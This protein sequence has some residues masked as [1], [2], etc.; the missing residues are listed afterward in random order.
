MPK[1]TAVTYARVSKKLERKGDPDRGASLERQE[2]SFKDFLA[3]HSLVRKDGWAFAESKSARTAEQR[4]TFQEM[5]AALPRLR[6]DYVVID[7]LDRFTRDLESGYSSLEAIKKLGIQ[8]WE[9]KF[10]E[11]RPF[12]ADDW[13]YIN[14]KFV[15]AKTE[16]ES[17]V[18][19]QIERYKQQRK[20]GFSTSNRAGFGLL[21]W[22]RPVPKPDPNECRRKLIADPDPLK[23][24]ICRQ[25]DEKFLSGWSIR[26]LLAWLKATQPKS[27]AWK[28]CRGLSL[29]LRDEA[30]VVRD[31]AT[32]DANGKLIKRSDTVRRTSEGNNYVLVGMRTAADQ[33]RIREILK[34]R[35]YGSDRP[36]ENQHELS[37]LVLC[38]HCGGRMHGRMANGKPALACERHTPNFYIAE[39]KVLALWD[40]YWDELASPRLARKVV[41]LWKDEPQQDV[42]AKK[43]RVLES[44]ISKLRQRLEQLNKDRSAAVR[45][46][47]SDKPGVVAEAEAELEQIVS[48]RQ[49]TESEISK[50]ERQ[51]L[52]IPTAHRDPEAARLT[53]IIENIGWGISIKTDSK[54]YWDDSEF[55]ALLREVRKP[56]VLALGFPIVHRPAHDVKGWRKAK[57]FK[58]TWPTMDKL[59]Q[60]VA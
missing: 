19:R 52:E 31:K 15:A 10:K 51:L 6:P 18:D 17:D 33:A 60:E 14:D 13:R 55:R 42:A 26:R 48:K 39:D 41:K 40:H 46:A 50:H 38:G 21:L 22:P 56:F 32:R 34:G 45:L 23:Q 20:D 7:K 9:V 3:Q 11:G 37:G 36:T 24:Q 47:G 12:N 58:M 54:G 16:H 1:L 4:A 49:D 29:Y 30:L 53:T 57:S 25:V 5:L 44:E 43:R 28:S 35:T 27:G 59:L 8:L 2:A